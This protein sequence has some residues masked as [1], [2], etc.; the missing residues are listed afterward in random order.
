MKSGCG[1]LAAGKCS[2]PQT[3]CCVGWPGPMIQVHLRDS[4]RDGAVKKNGG[5]VWRCVLRVVETASQQVKEVFMGL[6][7]GSKFCVKRTKL[8]EEPI[9]V[10]G[11]NH[12]LFQDH[13]KNRQDKN[14]CPPA[15]IFLCTRFC[16]RSGAAGLT[17]PMEHN[18]IR[19]P[20][21]AQTRTM[22]FRRFRIF[23][24]PHQQKSVV[25]HFRFGHART[26]SFRCD[27]FASSTYPRLERNKCLDSV[28]VQKYFRTNAKFQTY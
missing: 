26:S 9:C 8:S 14:T 13:H 6:D 24:S 19:L 7:S 20:P 15:F 1:N 23:F 5:I 12:R 11:A 21:K 27:F 18:F 10:Y 22:T 28:I 25:A 16:Y 4:P 3:V 17:C 2:K